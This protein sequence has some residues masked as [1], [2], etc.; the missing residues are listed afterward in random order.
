VGTEKRERQKANR[1]KRREE[2]LKAARASAVKRNVLRWSAVGLAALAAV[3]LI[4]WI[5]GAFDDEE[6][7]GTDTVPA[8]TVPEVTLPTESSVSLPADSAT[9][10]TSA[11]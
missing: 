3:V 9:A 6:E 11:P 1:A 8:L 5:G 10:T 7:P 4:A 2:E